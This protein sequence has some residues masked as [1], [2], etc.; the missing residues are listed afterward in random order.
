M[1]LETWADVLTRSMQD[2]WLGVVGF[3]P[4]LI[5]AVVIFVIG[6][7][8]GAV[9][10]RLVAQ[11]VQSLK[12]DN[13]L[14]SAGLEDVLSRSGFSLNSGAFLGGLV[15]WF[16]IIVFLVASLD[17]LELNQV[18]IFLQEVVLLYL[19]QVIVAVLIL[20]VAAVI[21]DVMQNLVVGAARAAELRSAH[22]LGRATKW[23]IVVFAILAAVNQLGVATAFVQTLFTGVVVAVAL[24]V[25]LAFGLGGQQAAGD[26]LDKVRSDLNHRG[27]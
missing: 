20:L 6:W 12:V 27:K 15:K 18:N 19:P 10:G 7:I 16:V 21:A 11:V 23:A 17:V 4:T 9:L 13:A 2:L 5:A 1:L 8:V 25:G 14:R 26:Y 3:V 24:A 22:F